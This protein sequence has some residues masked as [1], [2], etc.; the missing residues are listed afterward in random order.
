[1]IARAVQHEIRPRLPRR[2]IT[3]VE[4]KKIAVAGA[5]NALQELLGDNL[6]GINVIPVE[7]DGQ[8]GVCAK[9]FHMFLRFLCDG[10]CVTRHRYCELRVLVRFFASLRMTTSQ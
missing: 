8:S 4:K 3:P 6:V 7:G 5:L 1:V 2:E 10:A 9:C